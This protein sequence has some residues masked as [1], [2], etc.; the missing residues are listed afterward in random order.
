MALRCRTPSTLTPEIG[1]RRYLQ[2][3]R[4]QAWD[5]FWDRLYDEVSLSDDA[6]DKFSFDLLEESA[7][8]D[9]FPIHWTRGL[10]SG[11]SLIHLEQTPV[12]QAYAQFLKRFDTQIQAGRPRSGALARG[13]EVR[14]VP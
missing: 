8:H 1:V 11:A 5:L 12:K 2:G 7:P 10:A 14:P 4:D 6:G 9:P 13:A 3:F